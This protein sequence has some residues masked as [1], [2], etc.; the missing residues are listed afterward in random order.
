MAHRCL[1]CS[2]KY[3][4]RGKKNKNE[5]LQNWQTG[6]DLL[7]MLAADSLFWWLVWFSSQDKLARQLSIAAPGIRMNANNNSSTRPRQRHLSPTTSPW[8]PL[9]TI[10]VTSPRNCCFSTHWL[11]ERAA[12]HFPSW[13][14]FIAK[15][16]LQPPHQRRTR[17]RNKKK[18]KKSS[19]AACCLI[20]S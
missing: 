5:V 16:T 17:A 15:T 2:R 10:H 3:S 12:G 4:G 14:S 19:F 6:V 8:S 20:L 13:G 1:K 18:N 9:Q 11:Y 7:N